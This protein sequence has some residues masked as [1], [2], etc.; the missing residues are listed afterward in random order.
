MFYL[1][2]LVWIK[3]REVSSFQGWGLVVGVKKTVLKDGSSMVDLV[4]FGNGRKIALSVG[5]G[6]RFSFMNSHVEPGGLLL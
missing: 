6:K 2:D 1:G 5:D 4:V 3:E